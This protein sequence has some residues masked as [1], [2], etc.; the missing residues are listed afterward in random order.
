MEQINN[1]DDREVSET[2]IPSKFKNELTRGEYAIAFTKKNNLWILLW[3]IN[4]INLILS[5]VIW[6]IWIPLFLYKVYVMR[7]EVMIIT[8]KRI[9]GSV[10]PKLF[11]KD[12][13][14][15]KI[16]NVDNIQEDES[17]FG[18]IF[19]WTKIHVI[20]TSSKYTQKYVDK[21]SYRNFKNVFYKED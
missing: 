9:I 13:I 3:W 10:N 8:N 1:I 11:S 2:E 20:T 14:S 18:N 4:P 15:I 7:H 21:E 5:L 6:F 16:A 17:F 12:K 19:G